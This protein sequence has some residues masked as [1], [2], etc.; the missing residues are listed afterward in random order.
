MKREPIE[1]DQITD[2]RTHLTVALLAASQLRRR[3]KG[4]EAEQRLH[5]YLEDALTNLSQDIA[6]VEALVTAFAEESAPVPPSP[7]HI[8]RTVSTVGLLV[9]AEIR[10]H[11][12]HRRA[13]RAVLHTAG[14]P[15]R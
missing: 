15:L 5:G 10:Q 1:Y 13:A 8:L 3:Y 7:Q 12:R 14:T 2:M 11:M 9:M 4:L 6:N